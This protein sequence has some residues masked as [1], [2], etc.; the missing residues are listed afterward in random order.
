MSEGL[1][2]MHSN[3]EDLYFP[4]V[5]GS[6]YFVGLFVGVFLGTGV[7]LNSIYLSQLWLINMQNNN[8]KIIFNPFLIILLSLVFCC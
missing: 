6:G 8:G 4:S 5:V 1:G 3:C 2:K 7:I